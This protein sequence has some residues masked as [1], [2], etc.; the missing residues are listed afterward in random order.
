MLLEGLAFPTHAFLFLLELQRISEE[1]SNLFYIYAN[2]LLFFALEGAAN[3]VCSPH[4]VKRLQNSSI[5]LL[6]Q[7][8]HM[9]LGRQRATL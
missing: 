2:W 8:K 9:A 4:Y 6:A 7:S 3:C 1:S 5:P